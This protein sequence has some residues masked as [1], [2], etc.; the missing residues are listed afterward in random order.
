MAIIIV[1]LVLSSFLL[2]AQP[3]PVSAEWSTLEVGD[4]KP[5]ETIQA[6]VDD[7]V[8]GD[9]ILVYPGYYPESV[10]ITKSNLTLIAQAEGVYVEPPEVAGF[11]ITADR[12]TIRGFTIW[13]GI[14]CA[15]A[16]V[17]EGSFNTFAENTM[18]LS[19]ESPCV[20]GIAFTCADYDGGSDYNTIEN[21][22]ITGD[23]ALQIASYAPDALNKGNVVR[24]NL[25]D[26]Y[27]V[28][29]FINNGEGFSI[30]GNEVYS[31][32]GVCISIWA[33]NTI[34]QGNHRIKNNTATGC[35]FLGVGSGIELHALNGTKLTHNKISQNVVSQSFFSPGIYL[36]TDD[37][38]A[39]VSHNQIR[40]NTVYMNFHGVYL[41][42]GADNNLI[43]GNLVETNHG[44]G[45]VIESDNNK[46]VKNDALSN[47]TE[48]ISVDGDN[49]LIVN[50]TA[51]DNPVWDLADY[52][53]DNKWLS[54]E[55][56]TASWE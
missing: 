18:V 25:I 38:G 22:I 5:Y 44:M 28:A 40:D 17:F 9:T 29:L 6:A 12:V 47:A 1:V 26:G 27:D 41:G 45:I 42:P 21:N 49:N 35:G 23:Q 3:A 7:A 32:N 52:G 15:P 56:E 33:D 8:S 34:P 50:N 10:T 48:G 55:Y 53:L 19:Q 37:S 13:Y 4:D 11:H 46:I 30:S 54:N 16:I 51:L 2:I 39:V 31:D 20:G 24:D 14:L 36:H 43:L